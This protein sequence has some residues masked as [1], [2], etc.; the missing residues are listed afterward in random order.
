MDKHDHPY[1]CLQAQCAKLQG[2]TYSGGLLRHERKVHG[3]HG[4]PKEQLR[5]TVPECKRHTSKGFTRK[6]NLNE[7]LRRV[8]GIT[9]TTD[10]PVVISKHVDK[11]DHLYRQSNEEDLMNGHNAGNE[12]DAGTEDD[13]G[14]PYDVSEDVSAVQAL[15][16]RWL[17]SSASALLLKD[18]EPVT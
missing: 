2:F 4:A 11:H 13:M 8:H 15:L 9:S 16:N 3:K 5:C 7:H 18:D 10:R 1:R 17:D 12:D 14:R 6:E